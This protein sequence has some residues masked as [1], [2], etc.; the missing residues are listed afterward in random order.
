MEYSKY[1]IYCQLGSGFGMRVIPRDLTGGGVPTAQVILRKVDVAKFVVV[2]EN[3]DGLTP[4][5]FLD[6]ASHS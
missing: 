4:C 2:R 1:F 3:S 6:P 5:S